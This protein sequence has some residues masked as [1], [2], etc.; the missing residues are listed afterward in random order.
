M[1]RPDCPLDYALNVRAYRHK[2]L[3]DRGASIKNAWADGAGGGGREPCLLLKLTFEERICCLCITRQANYCSSPRFQ[4]KW[5]SRRHTL[6]RTMEATQSH[7]FC[8]VAPNGG[9]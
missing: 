2:A 6:C 5:H 3:G 1:T 4:S 9:G 7:E 8:L